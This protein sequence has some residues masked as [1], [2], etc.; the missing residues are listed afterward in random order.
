MEHEQVRVN[1]E[2]LCELFG[3]NATN[4]VSIDAKVEAG[5]VRVFAEMRLVTTKER[6]NHE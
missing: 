1:L 3:L 5:Y 4:V 2:E 6:R